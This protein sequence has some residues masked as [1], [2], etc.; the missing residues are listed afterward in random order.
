[1][2]ESEKCCLS[3]IYH[4]RAKGQVICEYLTRTAHRR[5]CPPGIE[6]TR[7]EELD[8]RRVEELYRQGKTDHE[9]AAATGALAAMVTQ[10]RHRRGLKANTKYTDYYGYYGKSKKM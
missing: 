1:M 9:I 7:R 5:G 2:K 6:C 3:C 4:G 8:S 10:W